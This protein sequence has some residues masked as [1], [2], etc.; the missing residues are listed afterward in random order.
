MMLFEYLAGGVIASLT[1]FCALFQVC[2]AP[3][4]AEDIVVFRNCD[5]FLISAV[6]VLAAVTHQARDLHLV[7]SYGTLGFILGIFAYYGTRRIRVPHARAPGHRRRQDRRPLPLGGHER[8]HGRLRPRRAAALVP[9]QPRASSL[10]SVAALFVQCA[11]CM[12]LDVEWTTDRVSLWVG[13][14]LLAAC[15]MAVLLDIASK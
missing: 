2:Y 14:I 15:F 8:R 12:L 1:V 11:Q 4:C 10:V 3:P 13:L 7:P 6:A 5:R 9:C